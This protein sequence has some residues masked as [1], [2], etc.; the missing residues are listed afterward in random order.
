MMIILRK[1]ISLSII[2][3]YCMAIFSILL[4]QVLKICFNLVII[5]I[6]SLLCMLN[7]VLWSYYYIDM[8][9]EGTYNYLRIAD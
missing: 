4:C 5:L 6:S 9:G 1:S 2:L 8:L 7:L 3:A